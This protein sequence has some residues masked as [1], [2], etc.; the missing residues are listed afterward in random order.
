[1]E[2]KSKSTSYIVENEERSIEIIAPHIDDIEH[3]ESTFFL[4]ET[5]SQKTKTNE[6]N[7]PLRLSVE[8]YVP[9]VMTRQ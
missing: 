7:Q 8:E 2:E 3:S 6:S 1:M 5:K 9:V 4:P